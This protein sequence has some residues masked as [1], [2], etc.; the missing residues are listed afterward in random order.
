MLKSLKYNCKI[1][2]GINPFKISKQRTKNA[3]NLFPVRKT[4]VA[5]TLPDPIFLIS[6][7]PNIFV[8]TKANG[9]DPIR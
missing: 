4:L 8:S 9:S 7:K 2:K 3:K 5:P 1:K 6:P